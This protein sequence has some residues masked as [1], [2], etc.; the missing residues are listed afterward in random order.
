MADL[1]II[2]DMVKETIFGKMDKHMMVNGQMGLKMVQVFGN[3]AEVIAILGS[4]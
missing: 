4:G 3:Q 1:K 2:K